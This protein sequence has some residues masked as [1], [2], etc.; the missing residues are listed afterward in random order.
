MKVPWNCVHL[1]LLVYRIELEWFPSMWFWTPCDGL[2]VS[3]IPFW[4]KAQTM[5]GDSNSESDLVGS[6]AM[7]VDS[8]SSE[9]PVAPASV[10]PELPV[11]LRRLPRWG[12]SWEKFVSL[13]R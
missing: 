2:L 7:L 10:S 6:P 9:E 12:S 4:I 11:R 3:A 8:S 13:K 5:D 1:L